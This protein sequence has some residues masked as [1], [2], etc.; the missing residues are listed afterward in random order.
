MS[1]F[2]AAAKFIFRWSAAS[3]ATERC[4]K[5]TSSSLSTSST[6]KTGLGSLMKSSSL[7]AH[8]SFGRSSSDASL[9]RWKFDERAHYV[10]V[11]SESCGYFFDKGAPH[12]RPCRALRSWQPRSSRL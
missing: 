6:A 11:F 10:I 3:F 4:T 8:G 2:F 1:S 5:R 12:T 9:R 7:L